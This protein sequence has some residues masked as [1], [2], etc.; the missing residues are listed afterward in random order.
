M[1]RPKGGSAPP[2]GW[3]QR[4]QENTDPGGGSWTISRWMKAHADCYV[5]HGR[6]WKMLDVDSDPSSAAFPRPPGCARDCDRR[7]TGRGSSA[8]AG[9]DGHNFRSERIDKT[10]AMGNAA[11]RPTHHLRSRHGASLRC[12]RRQNSATAIMPQLAKVAGT[13][14]LGGGLSSG[15]RWATLRL[16]QSERMIA[17]SQ[18]DPATHGCAAAGLQ[19]VLLPQKMRWTAPNTDCSLV[20][21]R[22]DGGHACHGHRQGHHDA[23]DWDH[24]DATAFDEKPS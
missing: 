12:Q 14:D 4:H 16:R 1:F 2:F 23:T 22:S 21:R 10:I 15:R 20:C 17:G 9:F 19:L 18:I 3:L 24:V 7:W 5:S 6:R 8:T 13:V 11:K